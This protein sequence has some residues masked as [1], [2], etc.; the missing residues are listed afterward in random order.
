MPVIQAGR[1]ADPQAADAPLSTASPAFVAVNP[2]GQVPAFEDDGLVLTESLA[3]V[4]HIGRKAGAPFG[5]TDAAED[6]RMQNW[7]LFI[8]TSVEP[9]ALDILY[10]MMEGAKDTPEGAARMARG[11]ASLVRPLARI[12]AHLAGRDWLI[13]DRF[14]V[15][16]ICLA[17]VLR[18]AQG[19]PPALAPFPAVRAWLAR[20]QARPAF[21]Q[22]MALRN[23]EPA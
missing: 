19:H 21:Q 7:A 4:L 16:D 6:A 9:G 8:A 14:T 2:M 18:Y 23:A 11:V 12:E 13:G 10:P 20:C 17:E 3:I 1:L 15:A 5:P 22:V